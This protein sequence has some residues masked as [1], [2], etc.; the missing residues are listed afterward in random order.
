MREPLISGL[1][2]RE[3][4]VLEALLLK[5]ATGTRARRTM[6]ARARAGRA[7]RTSL[8]PRSKLLDPHRRAAA[9][10]ARAG[11][12]P[13]RPRCG[14][15]APA[16]ARPKPKLIYLEAEPAANSPSSPAAADAKTKPLVAALDAR[17]AWPNKP[18][19][20]PPPVIKPLTPAE[21][22]L[23]DDGK[24]VYDSLCAACHQPTG[25]GMSG[26]APRAGR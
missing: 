9:Q 8:R 25:T 3:L 17:L 22:K 15:K 20:P 14:G 11:R 7:D 21:Q 6:L 4:E 18:G 10:F 16:K 1:R 24:V 23:F 26:L 5:L 12:A 13:R 19:V 2:G